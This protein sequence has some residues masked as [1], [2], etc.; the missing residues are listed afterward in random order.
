MKILTLEHLALF[1]LLGMLAPNAFG[2]LLTF[3]EVVAG[4]TTFA[5][6]GDGVDDVIFTTTDPS[7]FNTAGP[8]ANMTYIDEPGLEGTSLLNPDLRVDFQVGAVDS[9]TFGFALNSF[10]EDEFAFFDLYDSLDNLIASVSQ[11]GLYTFPDGF[12]RSNFPEGLI[13]GGVQRCCI[14]RLV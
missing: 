14:L 6:D 7:V 10:T 13:F 8:G 1:F 3:D 9:L 12:N 11:V 4:A 5:F 2:A